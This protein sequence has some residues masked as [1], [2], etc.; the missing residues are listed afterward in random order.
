[1]AEASLEL[2]RWPLVLSAVS[3]ALVALGMGSAPVAGQ[4]RPP[5]RIP[6]EIYAREKVIDAAPCA[7]GRLLRDIVLLA[8]R[9]GTPRRR[10]QA[11]VDAVEG[12]VVGGRRLGGADG[13]YV[14]RVPDDGSGA[15]LCRALTRLEAM[16]EVEGAVPELLSLRPDAP[17]AQQ[18]AEADNAANAPLH[19]RTSESAPAALRLNPR[20]RRQRALSGDMDLRDLP[21]VHGRG[22]ARHRLRAGRLTTH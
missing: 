4:A 14:V 17:G 6:S 13:F 22:A 5:D 16:P 12:V 21:P 20:V 7:S 8:F 19:S 15:G 2:R 10:R 18:R 1:M 11:V 9:S 3:A